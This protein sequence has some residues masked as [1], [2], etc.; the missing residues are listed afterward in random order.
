MYTH[1]YTK[2]HA[3]MKIPPWHDKCSNVVLFTRSLGVL[4]EGM[5]MSSRGLRDSFRV[6]DRDKKSRFTILV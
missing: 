2:P 4:E 6:A 1:V 5:L 3:H